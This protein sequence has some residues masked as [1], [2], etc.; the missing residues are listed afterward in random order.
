MP[1][2]RASRG[3]CRQ[4]SAAGIEAGHRLHQVGTPAVQLIHRSIGQTTE[5]LKQGG[6][7]QI[8]GRTAMQLGFGGKF[9]PVD[10]QQDGFRQQVGEGNFTI[11][12]A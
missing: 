11:A 3:H 10:R 1:T 6:Q 9:E 8:A 7:M 2:G 5:I 12:E 4:A